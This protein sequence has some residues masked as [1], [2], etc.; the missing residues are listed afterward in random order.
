MQGSQLPRTLLLLNARRRL[1]ELSRSLL[2]DTFAKCLFNKPTGLLA[3]SSDKSFGL[4]SRFAL[5]ADDDFNDLH[6]TPPFTWTVSLIDPSA[7][8]CSATA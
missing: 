5:R 8:G 4:Y 2:V 1:M 3:G 7:K 6:A